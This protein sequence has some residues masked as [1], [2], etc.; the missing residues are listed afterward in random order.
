VP[1][2]ASP[3]QPSSRPAQKKNDIA[4]GHL[5]PRAAGPDPGPADTVPIDPKTES[6][7]S[8]SPPVVTPLPEPTVM[9][10][11]DA[12]SPRPR[13]PASAGSS[14]AAAAP[15][16]DLV[17]PRLDVSASS[18]LPAA[19]GASSGESVS[20]QTPSTNEDHVLSTAGQAAWDVAEAERC[21]RQ[22]LDEIGGMTADFGRE[23]TSVAI[24]GPNQL[25]V[26]LKLAYNKEWCSRAEV[27]RKLEQTMS[28]L[29]GRDLRI[30]FHVEPASDTS[31]KPDRPPA[32]T[33]RLQKMRDVEKHPL[34]REA[35]QLFDAEVVRYD[36][37]RT[38]P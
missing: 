19:P 36:E 15:A 30:E 25:V 14:D 9:P 20:P 24:C 1:S 33:S 21:W 7:A 27:K 13:V 38:N 35:V 22:T 37:R 5:A 34:V 28:R 3:A 11:V 18:A 32:T 12:A 4:T 17:T 26:H 23:Y 16:G 2:V 29:A 10:A 6:S 8:S 31:A